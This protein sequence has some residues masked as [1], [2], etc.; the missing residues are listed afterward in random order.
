MYN[1]ID[2]GDDEKYSLSARKADRYLIA[3]QRHIIAGAGRELNQKCMILCNGV[4]LWR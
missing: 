2:I 4:R 1:L 3:D